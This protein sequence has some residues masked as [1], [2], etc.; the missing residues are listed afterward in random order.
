MPRSGFVGL[1]GRPNVGKST[2]VNALVGAKVAIISDRP[3]TTR[4][5]A[6][7][8]ATDVGAGWQMVLVDLPGV[9]K[10]RDV[11]SFPMD[12]GG[13]APGPRE[14]GDVFICPEHT[15]DVVEA[16]IH[17]VLH[18]CGFDHETDEGEMLTLQRQVLESLSLHAPRHPRKRS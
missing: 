12:G 18:L 4:R 7:G 11:L 6:R 8:V 2:L 16:A 10:P 9:Q 5:A 13:P 14:L 1:A 3:Q 15:E 17:G